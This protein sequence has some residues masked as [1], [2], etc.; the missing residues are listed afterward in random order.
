[1]TPLERAQDCQTSSADLERLAAHRDA[2]VRS[3]VAR[4]P[5]AAPQTLLRLC[6]RHAEDF[7]ANP[8][9]DLLLLENSNWLSDL[10]EYARLALLRHPACPVAWLE[11]ALAVGG[12][13]KSWL[14]VAQNP[15]CPE[16]FLVELCE[17]DSAPGEAAALH[18]RMQESGRA[19]GRLGGQL[20]SSE[21]ILPAFAV[22]LER[23]AEALKDLLA[24]R[25][26]PA[27]LLAGLAGDDDQELRLV[28]A[29]HPDLDD[30]SLEAFVFH[31]DEDTRLAA[32]ERTL[33]VDL[34][35]LL[36]RAEGSAEGSAEDC[37]ALLPGD[38]ERLARFP[39]GRL[40]LARHAGATPKILESL[41]LDEDWHVRQACGA[42]RAAGAGLLA[43]LAGDLDKDVRAAVAANPQATKSTLARLMLDTEPEVRRAAQHNPSTP[44]ALR[45][46][47]DKLERGDPAL[48][49]AAL[50][51]LVRRDD[52]MAELA[53]GHVN[54]TPAMLRAHASHDAWRVRQAVARN[55]RSP[56]EVIERLAGD[57]DY[58]VRAAITTN[59][60]IPERLLERFERDP[61]ALVRSGVALNPRTSTPALER[62]ALDEDSD[63]RQAVAVNPAVSSGLL[64]RLSRD[65]REAV[66]RAVALNP[67]T[68][69]TTLERLSRDPDDEVRALTAEHPQTPEACGAAL[70]GAEFP[71]KSM[72]KRLMAGADVTET[73]L[74]QLAGLNG[75]AQAL[76]LKHPNCPPDI[77][78]GF[79]ASESWQVRQRVA[80]HPRADARMLATLATD[81][82]YD[83]REAVA[84]HINTPPGAL[85]Q[86]ARDDQV[87]VRRGLAARPRLSPEIA[88]LLSWDDDDELLGA[89]QARGA[90]ELDLR[91]RASENAPLPPESLARLQR[92][93]TPLAL[94]LLA[95][96]PNTPAP[97]L[98]ELSLT[99]D[100]HVRQAVAR[101][102]NSDANTLELL[103]NDADA[104]VR[105]AVAANPITPERLLNAA[106]HDAEAGVRRAALGNP[107][108][109]DETRQAYRRALL[110]RA[111]T[112][113]GLTRV[114]AL[115]HPSLPRTEFGKRRN[116][117]A[118]LWL[119]R[120]A[121]ARNPSAPQGALK[122]LAL[123]ANRLVRA[124]ALESLSDPILGEP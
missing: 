21:G 115:Q 76:A 116:L 16:R 48:S 65:E 57:A 75:F 7:F 93:G 46:T 28:A 69:G 18:T 22:S 20:S 37:A 52:G 27:W 3:M 107:H 14:A 61:H 113:G 58:D 90:E 39:Y 32:R 110:N 62:L 54:A 17:Q 29:R 112:L 80:Q 36:T 123:D 121:L 100:W 88:E 95:Q 86:L 25:L 85:L 42:N 120:L 96:N 122:T 109:P 83:V 91:L 68:S 26:V 59:G 84:R 103:V 41:G 106:L 40:L 38:L 15:A 11:Y 124:A 51:R 105:R 102:P 97:T 108:L 71:W 5:N 23:D 24:A 78:H 64:E 56:L 49:S 53:L 60:R 63:V 33:P 92:I 47:L 89:L 45:D 81:G 114:V 101:H 73:E 10:P 44:A 119:E 67:R 31:A 87:V 82:D 77:L 8:V 70:F 72:Y 99:Y 50:E 94:R 74:R 55:P 104:D 12:D 6:V 2:A 118:L 19:R 30:A 66:R 35:E 43:R 9:L 13:P 4:N 34:R 117:H 1:M 79:A 98:A 111:L